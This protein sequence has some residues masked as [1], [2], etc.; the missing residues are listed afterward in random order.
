[1]SSLPERVR[2]VAAPGELRDVE[3]EVLGWRTEHGETMLRCRLVD[4]SVG[5]I[6]ARWSDLP[7][8]S[9]ERSVL[10]WSHRR[11]RGGCSANGSMRCARGVRV[12]REPPAKTEVPMSG[13][14]ALVSGG[15]L[16]AAAVWETLP[17]ERQQ[18]VTVMLARLLARLLEAERGE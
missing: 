10:G 13:Q 7:R 15:S 4:G 14:L 9:A 3:L 12:G 16:V 18:Q 2:L 5:T 6:P 1:V 11:R 17:P 8:V